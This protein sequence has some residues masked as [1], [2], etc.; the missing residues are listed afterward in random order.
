[1]L[2]IKFSL[3]TTPCLYSHGI[4]ELKTQKQGVAMNKIDIENK[5]NELKDCEYINVHLFMGDMVSCPPSN[6]INYVKDEY[7]DMLG[8][9]VKYSN[10][11]Y[12]D[13][14]Y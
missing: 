6:I 9:K 14:F 11:S 10:I 13:S 4:H 7:I 2:I 3:K 5:L 8:S 12:I 1:M